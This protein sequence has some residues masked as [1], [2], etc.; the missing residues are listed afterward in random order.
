MIALT[1]IVATTIHVIPGS[2]LELGMQVF[3][4]VTMAIGSF[5]WHARWPS[6]FAI[7]CVIEHLASVAQGSNQAAEHVA[8]CP[9]QAGRMDQSEASGCQSNERE[10]RDGGH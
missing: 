2:Q 5:A 8:C 1:A 3:S 7:P 10:D 4:F 6:L 9:T